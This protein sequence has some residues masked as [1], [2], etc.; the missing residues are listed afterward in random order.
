MGFGEPGCDY[1][2][3][4]LTFPRLVFEAIG[5][6]GVRGIILPGSKPDF[7]PQVSD[8]V[9]IGCRNEQFLD[10]LAFIVLRGRALSTCVL[11][12]LC[13]NVRF[14]TSIVKTMRLAFQNRIEIINS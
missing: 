3:I 7:I 4:T 11:P 13:C 2:Y 10:A 12:N 14:R 6:F 8:V 9:T 1:P 5:P